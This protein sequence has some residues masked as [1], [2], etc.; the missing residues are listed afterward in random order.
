M[1][2]IREYTQRG[3]VAQ[4]QLQRQA[5]LARVQRMGGP[6]VR[7]PHAIQEQAALQQKN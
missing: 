7:Y 5:Q 1:S 2:K 3:L 4:D 6:I